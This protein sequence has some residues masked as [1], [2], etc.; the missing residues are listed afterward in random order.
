MSSDPTNPIWEQGWEGHEA[1]QRER[2]SSL[3]LSEKLRWLEEAHH[4]V[5]HMASGAQKPAE[6]GDKD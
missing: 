6:R 2:M 5:L 4:L 1:H 3:P